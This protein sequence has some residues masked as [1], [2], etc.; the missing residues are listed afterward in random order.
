VPRKRDKQVLPGLE[1]QSGGDWEVVV[2]AGG[3]GMGREG[4]GIMSEKAD[5][6]F[7]VFSI[8]IHWLS[9]LR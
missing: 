2:M 7:R 4:G 9:L 1:I 3:M 8:L 6:V 5:K